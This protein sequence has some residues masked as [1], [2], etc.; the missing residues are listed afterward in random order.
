MPCLILPFCFKNLKGSQK[1]VLFTLQTQVQGRIPTLLRPS[2]AD[3]SASFSRIHLEPMI[4]KQAWR[5]TP[6]SPAQ[7]A[8]S[9]DSRAMPASLCSQRSLQWLVTVG[10]GLKLHSSFRTSAII[11]P[12]LPLQDLQVIEKENVCLAIF[13]Q[14]LCISH[15]KTLRPKLETFFKNH[16]YFQ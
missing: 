11:P 16:R 13:K 9:T 10:L 15:F 14:G 12:P 5:Y 2:S 8:V 6:C 4:Q 3:V 1:D 7:P